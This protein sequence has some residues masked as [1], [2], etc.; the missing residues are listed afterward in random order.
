MI[1]SCKLA[2]IN[3]FEVIPEHA[4]AYSEEDFEQCN[5]GPQFMQAIAQ[6]IAQQPGPVENESAGEPYI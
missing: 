5:Y 4:V 6:F 2:L 1:A 3:Q